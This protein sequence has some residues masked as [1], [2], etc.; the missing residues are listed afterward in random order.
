M[1]NKFAI[2]DLIRFKGS[3]LLYNFKGTL[4]TAK[5]GDIFKICAVDAEGDIYGIKGAYVESP[6][7]CYM[8]DYFELTK[9]S[10]WKKE[11]K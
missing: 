8:E 1:A 11:L 10:N 7:W 3:Y 9:I 5:K 2:G 4:G 6:N